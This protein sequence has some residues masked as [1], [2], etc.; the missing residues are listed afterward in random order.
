VAELARAF[1]PATVGNVAVGFDIL[2][3]AVKEIGDIVSVKKISEPQNIKIE[4]ITGASGIPTDPKK[5]TATV[6]LIRLAKDFNLPFGFSVSIEKGIP[7]SSGMGGSA[8]S[9]VAAVVAA[10][11]L[12]PKPLD[13]TAL[14]SY[15]LD[16][17]SLAS[18]SMHGDNLAPA[19]LGGLVL[20]Q[21]VKP[22]EFVQIPVPKNIICVL[23]HPHIEIETRTAR[24]ILKKDVSLKE[25]VHQSSLLAGF[26]SGCFLNDKAVISRSLKDHLIEPQRSSLIPGFTEAQSAALNSGAFGCSISGAGP[27]VFAWTDSRSSGE[28]IA[29]NMKRAFQ[30][31]GT[32]KVD[33]WISPIRTE[34]A[35]LI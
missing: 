29:D 16:G 9:A 26:I 28:K 21:S 8:A 19:L 35:A 34:G 20:V 2:G 3:F 14:F 18:G 1:A 12:L 23:V 30:K 13:E 4:K 33:S 15:A 17:E 7:L 25:H 6:G 27:T 24:K 22:F 11:A 32:E 10:N 5:N 31:N